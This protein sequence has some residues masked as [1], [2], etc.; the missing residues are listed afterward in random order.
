M[1]TDLEVLAHVVEDPQA[2]V[3]RARPESVRAKVA[4][5]LPEYEAAKDEP[6]YQ[7]RAERMVVE[8]AERAQ[9]REDR[10]DAAVAARAKTDKDM[11]DRIAADVAKQLA[12]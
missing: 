8:R 7:T 2:W 12:R 1:P 5:W 9:R 11:S 6:G 10:R 3:D 4:R